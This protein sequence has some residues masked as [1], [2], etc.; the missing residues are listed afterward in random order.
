MLEADKKEKYKDWSDFEILL[1]KYIKLKQT[2]N[3]EKWA[4]QERDIVLQKQ[5]NELR[6]D[7]DKIIIIRVERKRETGLRIWLRRARRWLKN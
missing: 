3:H 4:A 1:N 7:L 2:V 6:N 5:I